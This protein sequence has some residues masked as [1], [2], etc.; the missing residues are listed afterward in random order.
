MQ[1]EIINFFIKDDWHF[2]KI[3]GDSVLQTAFQCQNGKGNCY[4]KARE[5]DQ[6]VFYSICPVNAPENK[7]TA[8]AEFITRANYGTIIGNFELDYDD[9]EIRYKTSID[10]EGSNLTFDL[11]KQLVYTNVTMMNEYLPG[12]LSVIEGDVEPKDAIA[13]IES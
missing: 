6:F 9:G 4:A 1:E 13:Q 8:I 3:Q 5:E 7:R 11:I 12:I 10:V 2:S